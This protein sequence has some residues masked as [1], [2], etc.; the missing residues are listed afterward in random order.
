MYTIYIYLGKKYLFSCSG[1]VKVNLFRKK[2]QKRRKSALQTDESELENCGEIS[3][4]S[5]AN[6]D[7]L[8]DEENRGKKGQLS[9]LSSEFVETTEGLSSAQSF[10]QGSSYG[11]SDEDSRTKGV[12]KNNEEPSASNTVTEKTIE[13]KHESTF[14]VDVEE[15]ARKKAN[16]LE[17]IKK[18]SKKDNVKAERDALPTSG[19][20]DD[21]SPE[22]SREKKMK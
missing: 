9:S 10:I 7:D 6:F 22:D 4:Q 13:R 21:I 3:D 15:A 14:L 18:S 17:K 19:T 12:N 2:S 8:C 16:S 11:K 20:L 1:S 5:V